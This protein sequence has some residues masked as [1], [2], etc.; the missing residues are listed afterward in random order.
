MTPSHTTPSKHSNFLMCLIGNVC[1][2]L[3]IANIVHKYEVL[4]IKINT[5]SGLYYNTWSTGHEL[6]LHF[7][8][9][10]LEI[11]SFLSNF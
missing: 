5:Y 7:L 8:S 2:E 3:V 6:E 1:A 4:H 9:S 10:A 11:D